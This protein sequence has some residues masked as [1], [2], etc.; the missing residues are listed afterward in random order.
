MAVP[1]IEGTTTHANAEKTPQNLRD[2]RGR[3]TRPCGVCC[4]K[5]SDR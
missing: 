4:R 3:V 1:E 5:F 2:A